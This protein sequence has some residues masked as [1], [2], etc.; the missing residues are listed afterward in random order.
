MAK[1]STPAAGP[2]TSSNGGA[3]KPEK[4]LTKMEAVR[5][6]IARLGWEAKPKQIQ[7]HIRRRFGIEMTA[8]HISTYKGDLARKAGRGKAKP[9]PVA[10]SA[11]RETAPKAPAAAKPRTESGAIPLKDILA[12]KE[13]VGRLGARPLHTLIDAFAR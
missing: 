3:G 1:K 2:T 7:K 5:Q 13:L 11:T 8:D 10:A 6:A 9:A 12:V 4:K